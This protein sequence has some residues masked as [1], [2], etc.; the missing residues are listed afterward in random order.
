MIDK[1]LAVDKLKKAV[2]DYIEWMISEGYADSTYD[3]Y[4]KVLDDFMLFVSQNSIPWDKIFTFDTFTTFQKESR[5]RKVWSAVSGLAEYLF[6]EKIIQYPIKKPFQ[7]LPEIYEQYLVHYATTRQI[8]SQRVLNTRRTISAFNNYL[9]KRDIKLSGIG[10]E[11]IDAFLSERN[12]NYSSVSCATQRG[13]MRGFLTYLHEQKVI[14][15][16]LAILVVGA[17]MYAK[18]KPP[19]FFRPHEVEKLFA[20]LST[21]SPIMLRTSAMVHLAYFLGLRP[22]EISLICFDDIFF[23]QGKIRL[24]DRKCTNPIELVLPEIV[25]KAITA[26]ILEGRPNKNSERVIFLTQNVPHKPIS[27]VTVSRN[28]SQALRKAGLPGSAYWLRHTFGQN[29]LESGAT[30]FEIKEMMGHDCFQSSMK[31]LH[32]NIKLMREVLFDE[33]L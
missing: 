21:S 26:Y 16:N 30:S 29:L 10:I 6:K 28:I 33:P 20:N 14:K 25:I 24:P 15:R 5:Y 18:S 3:Q 11:H 4:G 19:K 17:P 9:E 2:N 1:K 32:I 31:Y 12:A 22:K 8:D 23:K 27:P 13:N 7:K